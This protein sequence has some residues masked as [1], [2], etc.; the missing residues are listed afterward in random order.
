[1][2]RWIERERERERERARER[3]QQ[4]TKDAIELVKGF[5]QES[6]ALPEVVA[7]TFTECHLAHKRWMTLNE[8]DSW[9]RVRERERESECSTGYS[10][11]ERSA[12][13]VAR[14]K[15]AVNQWMA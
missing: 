8:T 5:G 9:M 7:A 12:A 2:K 1:M 3:Q 13:H 15:A 11:Q 6:I 4:L 14:K 10:S